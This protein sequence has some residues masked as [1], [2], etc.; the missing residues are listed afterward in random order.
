MKVK[1]FYTEIFWGLSLSFLYFCLKTKTMQMKKLITLASFAILSLAFVACGPSAEEIKKDSTDAANLAAS[2]NDDADS[3]IN[4]MNA[5]N[6]TN[7]TNK[8]DTGVKK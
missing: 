5:G 3:I 6:E 8:S 1:I 4:A 2:M 7:D